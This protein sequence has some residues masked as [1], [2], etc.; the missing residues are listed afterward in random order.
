L[1]LFDTLS[2]LFA[3]A[4]IQAKKLGNPTSHDKAITFLVKVVALVGPFL[5]SDT[6]SLFQ[7]FL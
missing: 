4:S 6:S 7:G 1:R 2:Y 5:S 3:L